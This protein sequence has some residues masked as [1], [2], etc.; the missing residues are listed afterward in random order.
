MGRAGFRLDRL[1]GASLQQQFYAAQATNNVNG[2][3]LD[4]VTL[5]VDNPVAIALGASPLD[6][7]Q[8]LSFSAG[9]RQCDL[10]P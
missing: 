8:S 10:Q 4:T 3:L 2:V 6:A 5:P 1:P 7:E 9:G